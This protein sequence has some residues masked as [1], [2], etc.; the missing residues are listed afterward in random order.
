MNFCQWTGYSP[1][2][3][4]AVVMPRVNKKG[5]VRVQNERKWVY[6]I[7]D[8]QIRKH[9]IHAWYPYMDGGDYCYYH[10]KLRD[11]LLEPTL[12]E[13]RQVISRRRRNVVNKGRLE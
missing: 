7:D 9:I 8:H 2:R 3:C 10:R 4:G 6:D 5:R 12:P 1:E 11:N 13:E